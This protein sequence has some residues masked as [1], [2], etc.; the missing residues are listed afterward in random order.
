MSLNV[1]TSK[2]THRQADILDI[3]TEIAIAK[4]EQFGTKRS[5][6]KRGDSHGGKTPR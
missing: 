1:K 6:V 4:Y 3:K 2:K 5:P